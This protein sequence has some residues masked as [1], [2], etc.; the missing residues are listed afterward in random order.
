MGNADVT[1]ILVA[2]V[3]SVQAWTAI[4]NSTDTVLLKN[5]DLTHYVFVGKRNNIS[6]TGLNVIP[7]EPNGSIV[8]SADSNWFV[9]GG[10]ANI[11][12]L[13]VIP[14]GIATFR[15]LSQ[16]Q[17]NL[18]LPQFQSPNYVPG[19]SGW[20]VFQNGNSEFNNGVF[21][22]GIQVGG[23]TFQYSTPTPQ[24]NTLIYSNSATAGQDSAGN[25]FMPGMV[26][27]GADV[28]DGVGFV[29]VQ[30]Y[31][32]FISFAWVPD[33][34]GA[35]DPWIGAATGSLGWTGSTGVRLLSTT[36]TVTLEG[37]PLILISTSGQI[38]SQSNIFINDPL[39][40][41]VYATEKIEEVLSSATGSLTALTTV[42]SF[43]GTTRTYKFWL[44]LYVDV[45]V[46]NAQLNTKIVAPIGSNGVMGVEI[47]RGGTFFG[48]VAGGINVANG[49]AVNLPAAT[50]YIVDLDC[51][52]TPASAG[53]VS[54]Q[55]GSLTAQGIVI[56]ANSDLLLVPQ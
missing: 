31:Q 45:A 11:A 16:G 19:V 9:I 17:G 50:G 14:G 39:D 55:F 6:P 32:G 26:E 2:N 1:Q 47:K 42:F 22:G 43:N 35:V 30:A 41:N 18:A 46:A 25:W 13:L 36:D 21:R 33:M 8:V 15:G 23:Q 3:Q 44:R 38:T 49:I 29:A 54:I 7:I 24:P 56:E 5:Q 20:A 10:A 28:A 27:Y 52:V 12:N 34:T 37:S 51:V 40:G 4:P 48:C 53:T